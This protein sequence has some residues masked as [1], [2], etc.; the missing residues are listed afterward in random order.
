MSDEERQTKISTGEE[1]KSKGLRLS[2][3]KFLWLGGLGTL[4]LLTVGRLGFYGSAAPLEGQVLARWEAHT[5]AAAAEALIPDEPGKWPA[6]GPSPLEVAANVDRFL[7]GMP[8]GMLR[9]IRAMFGFIEHG[10]FLGARLSRFTRLSAEKRL[11][12]LVGLYERGGVPAEAFEGIRALCLVGWYQDDRTWEALGYGGPLMSRPA[13]PK[14]VTAE[15]AGG[16][17]DL[18]AKPGSAPQG[19]L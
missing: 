3:R 12:V 19:V 11:D 5:L 16:Y 4:G 8:R 1:S 2:R 7:V 9:E 10:T 6:T 13:P 15:D 17:A 18:M 14:A